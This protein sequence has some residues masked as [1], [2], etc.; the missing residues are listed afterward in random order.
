MKINL[1]NNKLE[2]DLRKTV[3]KLLVDL[4]LDYKGSLLE[5]A[6]KLEVNYN[7]LSMALTGYRKTPGSEKILKNL[8]DFLK[9]QKGESHE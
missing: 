7:A 1:L 3:K 8:F 4:S 6:K 2:T 5:L 9:N